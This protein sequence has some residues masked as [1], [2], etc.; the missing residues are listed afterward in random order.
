MCS[1]LVQIKTTGRRSVNQMTTIVT[2]A[3]YLRQHNTRIM[4]RLTKRL[5]NNIYITVGNKKF[6]FDSTYAC[7]TKRSISIP[8]I[9]LIAGILMLFT[10]LCM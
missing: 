2:V 10:H 1:D 7:R 6:V 9:V 3:S 4:Y 8:T 5:N